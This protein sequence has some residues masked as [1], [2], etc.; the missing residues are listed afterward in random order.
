MQ[1]F[2]ISKLYI[3]LKYFSPNVDTLLWM[4]IICMQHFLHW[5][6][7]TLKFAQCCSKSS[8]F[9]VN[10][11][12][13]FYWYIF[14]W[15]CTHL[16]DVSRRATTTIIKIIDYVNYATWLKSIFLKLYVLI[17]RESDLWEIPGN[18]WFYIRKLC[19]SFLKLIATQFPSFSPATT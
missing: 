3:L 1:I 2:Y 9:G 11:T 19:T 14:G 17:F 12:V 16:T 7:Q 18:L 6:P 13:N 15:F 5:D 8:P 10:W 4:Y